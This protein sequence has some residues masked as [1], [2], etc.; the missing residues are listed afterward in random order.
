MLTPE[1]ITGV[2]IMDDKG[3]PGA[4]LVVTLYSEDLW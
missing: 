2:A 1:R 3:R 4:Q